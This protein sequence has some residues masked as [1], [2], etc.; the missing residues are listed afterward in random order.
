MESRSIT[1]RIDGPAR[2]SCAT[3]VF[4]LATL[5][6]FGKDP[7]VGDATERAIQQSSLTLPGSKPFHLKFD[8]SETSDPDTDD[9]KASVEEYWISPSK[10][11]RVITSQD[12][13]QTLITNGD[14]VSES[15][16]GDY[17][18][19]WLSK[20]V[21][22]VFDLM[23]T[24]LLDALKQAKVPVRI[25]FAGAQ[26]CADIPQRVDRWLICFE[27]RGL[28]ESI[29][30]KGYRAEFKDYKK[31]GDKWVARD[32][33][34][35]PNPGTTV[36]ARISEL[37]ELR[38]PDDRMFAIDRPTPPEQRIKSVHVDET[39]FNELLIG[40][41]NIDWPT[42]GEGN[43]KGGCGLYVSADRSGKIREAM[44]E[45]CDNAAME[46]P[47]YHAAMK[48]QLKPAVSDGVPVQIQVLLGIPF[49]TTLD[50]DKS[51][52]TLSDSEAR[53]LATNRVEPI[54]PQNVAPSGTEF[55][56]QISVDET[57]KLAGMGGAEGGNG[58]I[59][60]AIYNAVRQWQFKPYMKDGKPQYFHAKL[61][62]RMP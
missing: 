21:T 7:L 11:R 30:T 13:S 42:V 46:E 8:I 62:F 29:F 9:Y 31:F 14:A 2:F 58:N 50:P 38:E 41:M 33:V 32:I 5:A 25:P 19:F 12:F 18:P 53:A 45:G 22:A 6:V 23:P 61:V 34:D 43:L 54:F 56:V 59:G 40:G 20:F 28:F 27:E 49:Q 51:L 17:Y 36:E 4:L 1:S 16:T 10:W 37:Q 24:E 60:L 39:T 35:N 47:L 26:N 57:G 55:T 44:P 15:D 52:P 48:W 3:I